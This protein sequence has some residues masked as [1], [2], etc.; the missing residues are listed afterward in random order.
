MPQP[1]AAASLAPVRSALLSSRRLGDTKIGAILIPAHNEG[2]VIGR[3]LDALLDGLDPR[4]VDLVVS[5]NGCTDDTAAVAR[6][7]APSA[8]V[9][10]I[11]EASKAAA[12][13]AAEEQTSIFPRLYVDA[14]V[15][16][17]GSAAMS[18]LRALNNGAVAARPPFVYNSTRSSAPVRAYFRARIRIPSLN[19]HAW[20]A[21]VYGL[22]ATARSRFLTF[23]DVVADDLLVD[24][25]LRPG[26]LEV[27][28][29]DPVVVSTP[30]DATSLLRVLRRAQRGKAEAPPP[31]GSSGAADSLKA[32][33]LRLAV[34]GPRAAGDAAAFAVLSLAA[35]V[36]KRVNTA[37]AWERDDSSR[38]G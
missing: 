15:I 3:C 16:V 22:S 36:S 32:Q 8:T 35:R 6:Q 4:D 1:L 25:I 27:V 38:G 26:E 33:V 28:D 12:L 5:C 9:L 7:H 29:T 23:P 19:E 30:R 20:G 21:G 13:R 17:R 11:G 37:A 14:D 2:A 34:T 18:V 24:R 31:G 10:E